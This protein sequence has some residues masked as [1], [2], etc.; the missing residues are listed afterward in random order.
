[1]AA[2]QD[3]F[4]ISPLRGVFCRL[5]HLP[6]AADTLGGGIVAA[7][8]RQL[9]RYAALIAPQAGDNITNLWLVMPPPLRVRSPAPP[10]TIGGDTTRSVEAGRLT[11]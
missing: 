2:E 7:L 9:R 5:R 1:V 11:L 10:A 4:G 3:A 6:V 8:W